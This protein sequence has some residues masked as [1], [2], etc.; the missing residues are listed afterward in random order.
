MF[1]SFFPNPKLF[2][3]LALLWAIISLVGWYAVKSNFGAILGLDVSD[4]TPVV[5]VAMFWSPSFLLLY[6]YYGAAVA[7]F[8]IFFRTRSF[9]SRW[10]SH[11][12]LSRWLAGTRLEANS[13]RFLV[14]TPAAPPLR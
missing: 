1:K 10:H 4:A 8:Y 7:L 11:G 5:G 14:S 3:P 13:A 2:F 6:L 9:S 12:R